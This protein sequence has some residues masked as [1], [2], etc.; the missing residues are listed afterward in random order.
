[1]KPSNPLLLLCA[2]SALS[3]TATAD[4]AGEAAVDMSKWKCESCKFEQGISGTADAVAGSVSD[5]SAEFGQY[6]GLYRKGAFLIGDGAVR[7][8]NEDG[9]Y[10]NLDASNLGLKTQSMEA[11]GGKQGSYKLRFKYDESL[12]RI[13]DR[14]LTPY[15]G[16]GGA[17]LTL[18]AGFASATTA[19]MPL[20]GAMQSVDLAVQRKQLGVGAS[21]NRTK[22]WEYAVNF[23]HDTREGNILRT[24]GAFFVNSTQLVEPVDYITDQMDA[25]ASY[26]SKKFQLKL[27]YYGSKF[28]NSNHA[29]IWQDAYA[30]I[31]GETRG[32]LALPPDNQFH[33]VS[34]SAGYQFSDRTRLSGDVAVGRGTQSDNFLPFTQN[35]TLAAAAIPGSSPDARVATLDAGLKLSSAVNERL[36]LSAAYTHN[37]R[38]NRTPQAAYSYVVTDMFS[39]VAARTN[40]PYSFKQDKV[41]LS[42]DYKVSASLRGTVG[43]DFDSNKRTLQEVDTTRES[44]AWGK[45]GT[46]VLNLVDLSLKLAHAE[47]RNS[48]SFLA[49]PGIT[50]PENPLLR[51]F[52]MANRNR[53]TAGLRADFAVGERANI[54]LGFESSEDKY[55][56]STIG[57]SRAK[58]V[59]LNAD[60]SLTVSERTRL[61]LFANR[62]EIKSKQAGSQAFSLPDWNAD[63]KDTIDTFGLGVKHAAIPDKLDLGA[64]YATTRS[65]SEINVNTGAS[66]PAFPHVTASLDSLK[67]YA[68]YKLKEN[69]SLQ[70]GY[71]IERYSSRDWMLEG[72]APSTIPNVLTLGLQA[73]QYNVNVLRLSLRYKF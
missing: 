30:P 69:L 59:N 7:S 17:S 68:A 15:A 9:T 12:H 73:P 31:A 41:K 14:A 11:E 21:W 63:N 42:A 61:H 23:R 39:G 3:S 38:D 18:P 44:T 22:E 29:L 48:G 32:Q 72:V 40:L 24:G 6:N 25:S 27:A 62:Q 64:D 47:R 55:S 66:N 56:E 52:N 20:A 51:R 37:D 16:S 53:E 70:A 58:D 8:R 54:G 67:L 49:Q 33:Q 19:A 65:R 36:R 60:L 71:W 2:L 45:L 5:K 10:W 4:V 28:R 13:W 43:A 1:M 35:A 26:A 34:A 50:P 57:L 46:R